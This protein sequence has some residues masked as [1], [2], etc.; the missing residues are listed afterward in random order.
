MR[1][2]KLHLLS[3]RRTG[4]TRRSGRTSVTLGSGHT[5]GAGR[6]TGS[7]L[8][9]GSNNSGNGAFGSFSHHAFTDRSGRSRWTGTSGETRLSILTRDTSRSGRS[10]RSVWA[11]RSR[12]SYNLTLSEIFRSLTRKIC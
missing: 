8:S 3:P 11:G 6:S 1:A 12:G 9:G 2:A 4:G 7:H 5:S 10:S